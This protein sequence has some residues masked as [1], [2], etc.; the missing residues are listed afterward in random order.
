MHV[1]NNSFAL[2][3][4]ESR[5]RNTVWYKRS[6]IFLDMNAHKRVTVS[7]HL[8]TAA[9][10]TVFFSEYC[11]IASTIRAVSST[12]WWQIAIERCFFLLVLLSKCSKGIWTLNNLKSSSF[13]V[14][15]H[16]GVLDKVAGVEMQTSFLTH[17]LS[18]SFWVGCK[19]G[20]WHLA[21]AHSP[22]LLGYRDS[23]TKVIYCIFS[24]VSCQNL[25]EALHVLK[26]FFKL[27]GGLFLMLNFEHA[28]SNASLLPQMKTHAQARNSHL[29]N[30]FQT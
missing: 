27:L 15:S 17:A 22:S 9:S 26:H 13:S 21:C 24:F 4:Y 16:L 8:S 1:D 7:P 2:Q 18:L 10:I 6:R 14:D 29:L 23:H 3:Q 25:T 28:D 19:A 11:H 20:W 12:A 30:W 5:G